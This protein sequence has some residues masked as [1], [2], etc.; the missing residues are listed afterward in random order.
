VSLQNTAA[1]GYPHEGLILGVGGGIHFG[2]S[3]QKLS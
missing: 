3:R 2:R 1:G